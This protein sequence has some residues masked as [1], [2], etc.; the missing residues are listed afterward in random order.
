MQTFLHEPERY[1]QFIAVSDADLPLGFTEASLRTDHVNGT[2]SSPVA[3]LEGLY[4]EPGARRRGVAR[5]LVRAVISWA[6]ERSCIELA[7]DT[8]L[9]NTW[10][11]AVHARLGF[12]ETER[13]VY[14]RMALGS[15][16]AARP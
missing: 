11:Q 7:S 6:M 8:Q 3:F 14:F 2:A 5:A 9:E 1:A 16:N 12:E 10:S 4:V 15:G 13:V